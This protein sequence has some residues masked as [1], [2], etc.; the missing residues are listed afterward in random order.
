MR[1]SSVL[2]ELL[3]E[4]PG[5]IRV[6]LKHMVV[7]PETVMTAHLVS[8]AAAKQGK[9]PQFY[10]AFWDKAFGPYMNSQGKDQ[11][12]M[13]ESN[14]YEIAKAVGVDV[15]RAKADVEECKKVIEND[16]AELRRWGVSGTPAFFINGEFVGGGI[17]K[18]AFKQIIDRKLQTFEASGVPAAQY[19]EKVIMGTGDKTLRTKTVPNP[20]KC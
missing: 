9:F 5:K 19:Y 16:Q 6:V 11:S 2:K 20:P 3:A 1:A 8:C 17:P 18:D 13:S 4:Y 14:T 12:S 10:A 15:N 7:H